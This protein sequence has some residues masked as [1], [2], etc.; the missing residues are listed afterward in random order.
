VTT[1]ELAQ[2]IIEMIAEAERSLHN[3]PDQFFLTSLD[4]D[5]LQSLKNDIKELCQ[6]EVNKQ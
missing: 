6:E 1:Q 3:K 5:T 2:K 4:A